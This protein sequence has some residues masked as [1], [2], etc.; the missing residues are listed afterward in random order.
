MVGSDASFNIQTMKIT[1]KCSQMGHTKNTNN[2]T[3]T[4]VIIWL[5]NQF[6]GVS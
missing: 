1:K 4:F 3:K 5:I 2:N 6:V